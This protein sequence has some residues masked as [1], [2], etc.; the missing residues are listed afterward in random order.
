MALDPLV[1]IHRL[2]PG[3]SEILVR[4]RDFI[5]LQ[6][7]APDGRGPTAQRFRA[8]DLVWYQQADGRWGFI[9]L[10]SSQNP[11]DEPVYRY[12]WLQRFSRDGE[13]LGEPIDL[14]ETLPRELRGLNWE[15][16]DWFEDER[17]VV[18]V[19]ERHPR[20]NTVAY[21]LKLPASWMPDD[22]GARR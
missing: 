22:S 11:V 13:R 21:I 17:S 1:L 5:P 10:L 20:P 8:P 9:V 15:G 16:L 12:H 7:A 2:K 18:L 6:V 14:D 19:H 4:E 3:S